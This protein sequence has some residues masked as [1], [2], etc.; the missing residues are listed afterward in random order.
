MEVVT[1]TAVGIVLEMYFEI[2][3]MSEFLVYL[4]QLKLTKLKQRIKI[5][6]FSLKA[7]ETNRSKY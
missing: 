6:K 2:F 4:T 1:S 7:Y 5:L 3:S